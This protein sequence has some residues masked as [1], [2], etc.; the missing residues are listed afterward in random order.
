M[1]KSPV[2][3]PGMSEGPLSAEELNKIDPI[4]MR[5]L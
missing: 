4:G 2:S 5:A 1:A 3:Q